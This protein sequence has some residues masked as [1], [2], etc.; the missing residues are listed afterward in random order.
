[1]S[2]CACAGNSQVF[3]P[4]VQGRFG[5]DADAEGDIFG[6]PFTPCTD[7]DDWY[8]PQSPN[9]GNSLYVIDTTGAGAIVAGYANP[10]NRNIPLYR[11]MSY[12]AFS[13][14]SERTLIDAIFVRD[15][16]NTDETTFVAG[17]NKNGDSPAT[18]V[19][20]TTNNVLQKNDILDTYLHLRR[21]GP[22]Y[23]QSD[24]LWLYGAVALEATNGNRYFDFELYQTDI[25]YTRSTTKFTGYGPDAGHTSWKFDAA[26][27]VT[28]AGD[29]VFSA[30]YSGS[31]DYIEA[32]IWVDRSALL[33]PPANFSW[34]GD[35]D[36]AS[37]G[38]Q[39]GYAVIVPKG[40][41][42]FYFGLENTTT[43]WA[44]PFALP[45]ASGVVA[46]R[47]GAGQFME[48][49]INL[50]V[51]G[52]DPVSLMG[53]TPCGIPFSKVM[54]KTRTSESF[55]S[56]LK[57]FISP[58]DFFLPPSVDVATDMPILCGNHGISHVT[59]TNPF[60]T[61]TY[62]WSTPDGNIVVNNG[63]DITVD[64]PGTYKVVQTLATGCPLYAAD[65]ASITFDPSCVI[66]ASNKI[67]L[68]GV[69]NNGLANLD[70]SVTAN[71]DVKYFEIERSTDGVHY[72]L[73]GTVNATDTRSPNAA[74]KA[75]DGVFGLKVPKVYYRI[76]V[77]GTDGAVTYSKVIELSLAVNKLAVTL[78]PNPVNNAVSVNIASDVEK[79]VQVFVYDVS[80][81]L[82]RTTIAHVQKGYSMI[83]MN[84]LGSWANGVYSVKVVSGNE[85]FVERMLIT[86]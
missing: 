1:M 14:L 29:M 41:D 25:F 46:T 19:G 13:K 82:M 22:N 45:R 81:R 57:D 3:T 7:C 47:F 65:S 34:T 70:W 42:P 58:F 40:T 48:F 66:L 24:P 20:A 2:I 54:V 64:K 75:N 33:T 30:N 60:S 32:R 49:G 53:K 9:G 8:F 26:G 79:E 52:L 39:Y 50:T 44:G 61:S 69:L 28:Q 78:S 76:R 86:K 18:W 10:A 62:T 5:I 31:L 74:Y 71:N 56:E 6:D 67:N 15:Y 4:T 80:G 16:H 11:K 12:P 59:V 83:K 72:T 43:A 77:T 17:S 84:D 37:M 63:T 38:A 21:Q 27:N 35:F 36:G 23:N 51:L 68:S 55:T 73:A 85:V